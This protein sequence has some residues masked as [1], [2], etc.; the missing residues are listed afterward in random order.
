MDKSGPDP[1]R[2]RPRWRLVLGY[3][4]PL[5]A[6]IAAHAADSATINPAPT[7]AAWTAIADLPDLSGVW[8]P[9]P[10][11]KYTP[12]GPEAP[13][14]L[15][16][17]ARQVDHLKDLDAQGHPQNIY[18]NCL[19]EGL[20][21]SVTQNLNSVE[22]L[23]TPG[24]VTVLSEF[25]G[26]RLRRIWTDGRPHPAD[27]DPSFSGH[28]IGHWESNS[29][30]RGK[31]LVVDTVG[32]LPEVFIPLSQGVGFPNNGNMHIEERIALTGPDTLRQDIVVHAPKV[33]AAPWHA[34]RTYQ[35]HRERA[36]DL[37]E[38]SCRQGDFIE[39]RDAEGNAVF[40]PLAK[41]AGGATLPPDQ[42]AAPAVSTPPGTH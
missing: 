29:S 5:L 33:L 4:T 32:F 8:A 22:F 20:P 14:W 3:I 31:T 34:S 24:R 41:D 12:G 11:D 27:P 19:P 25:D 35:R 37:A 30:G 21:S 17:V 13:Q 10:L 23:L 7:R 16:E 6:P 42:A 36:Y 40:V 39:A 28:S 15:P 18:I 2:L 38:S 26:N 9:G 1:F